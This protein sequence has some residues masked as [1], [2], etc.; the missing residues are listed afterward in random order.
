MDSGQTPSYPPVYAGDAPAPE[1]PP[2]PASP[3]S[4]PAPKPRMSAGA[5]WAIGL[6]VAFVALIF[7]SCA[8]LAY[9]GLADSGSSV[10]LGD[11][12][13]VIHIDGV[14][15]GTGSVYDGVVTPE[16]VLDQL[17]QALADDSVKAILLRIDSPGGTVAA[18]QEISMAVSRASEEKPVVASIGDIGASGAY[19][20]ASQCDSIVAAPGSMVGSIGVIMEIPNVSGLLDKLGV[21][22]TVLTEGELKD[23][24]SPY[25]SATPTETALLQEQMGLAY[26]DFIGRVAEGRGL[27]EA[28]VRELATGWAWLGSE[29]VDLGLADRLGNWDDA[30][31]E[32][33][34]L[35]GI[36]GEPNLVTFE[37]TYSVE[38]LLLSLIG[39]TSRDL[40]SEADSLRRLG[41]PK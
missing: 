13:A 3:A 2:V 32:A 14:I 38:D 23:V 19:M 33:S 1:V 9:L 7:F 16:Y 25:R 21:E 15:A 5:K 4:A 30:V 34:S 26:D 10:A 37:P 18:S 29:A 12:I 11:S 22:F 39:L 27:D 6:G 35:G 36:D 28:E 40:T 17:D 31:E 8:G 20:V 24:G 41:L